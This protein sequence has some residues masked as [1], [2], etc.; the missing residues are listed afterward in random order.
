METLVVLYFIDLT[1]GSVGQGRVSLLDLTKWFMTSKP[2]ALLKMRDLEEQGL[3][4]VLKISILRG[5][6]FIYKFS[7][8]PEGK[9]HLDDHYDAA[10]Q[11][12]RI[13]VAKVLAAIEANR[14]VTEDTGLLTPKERRQIAAGQKGMFDE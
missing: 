2:T 12:Y 10:Y 11:M 5:H 9:N 8:T 6:G 1:F 7:L 14:H 4:N 3:V 13:H